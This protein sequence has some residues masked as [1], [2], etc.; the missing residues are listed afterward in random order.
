VRVGAAR[1]TG[2]PQPYAF[3]ARQ[4]GQRVDDCRRAVDVG[5]AADQLDRR[6]AAGDVDRAEPHLGSDR[7]EEALAPLARPRP[8]PYG[9][10]GLV[11]CRHSFAARAL[12]R[13]QHGDDLP[14]RTV[15]PES[16]LQV[17]RDRVLL[18]AA[19]R[20]DGDSEK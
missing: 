1:P 7:L 19:A 4:L 15:G 16:L 13:H 8:L 18:A 6:G 3:H 20:E 12:D 14:R 10:Y 2:E 11:R 5:L 17:D 9:E